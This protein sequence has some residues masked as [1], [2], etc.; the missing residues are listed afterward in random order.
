MMAYSEGYLAQIELLLQILPIV[1]EQDCF[2]LK[3]GTAINLFIRDMPRLS[4]D[5]DLT[6]LPIE[7]R[8]LFLENITTALNTLA[9]RIKEVGRG[10][11]QVSKLMTKDKQ[12][13]K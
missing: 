9:N 4:V 12:L 2:A 13:A 1:N 6:Y 5:I 10:R 3:G 7:P 8:A 11:Y